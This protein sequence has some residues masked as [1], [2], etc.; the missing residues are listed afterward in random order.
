MKKLREI[1]D[2]SRKSYADTRELDYK[3]AVYNSL[4]KGR[5][6]RYCEYCN[7][8]LS[9]EDKEDE[10]LQGLGIYK[11]PNCGKSQTIDSIKGRD[12]SVNELPNV[13][14]LFQISQIINSMNIDNLFGEFEA[15]LNWEEYDRFIHQNGSKLADF[16]TF[17]KQY[18]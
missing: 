10:D 15:D 17:L 7:E 5:D 3:K 9:Y 2:R 11:C 16:A 14:K 12:K 8:E 6:V 13:Q 4:N 1:F 18:F